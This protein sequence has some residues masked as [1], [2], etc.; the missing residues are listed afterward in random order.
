MPEKFLLP[1]PPRSKDFGERGSK[2]AGFSIE[3]VDHSFAEP[4][5]FDEKKFLDAMAELAKKRAN[6]GEQLFP[7]HYALA[8][9]LKKD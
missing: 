6:A 8:S 2:R 1:V 4:L 5:S 7:D 9:A 3:P